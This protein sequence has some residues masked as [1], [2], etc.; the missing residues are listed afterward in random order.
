MLFDTL[1]NLLS[2]SAVLAGLFLAVAAIAGTA[3]VLLDRSSRRD[4]ATHSSEPP[5]NQQDFGTTERRAN[6]QRLQQ[7]L[8]DRK[9]ELR[10]FNI[11]GDAA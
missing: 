10:P 5:F 2:N 4:E 7:R 9:Q 8:A 1:S 6:V 11:D 3:V